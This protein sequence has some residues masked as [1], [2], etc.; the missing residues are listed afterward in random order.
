MQ[1]AF[2]RTAIPVGRAQFRKRGS[3]RSRRPSPSRLKERTVTEIAADGQTSGKTLSCMNRPDCSTMRPQDGADQ[4]HARDDRVEACAY[5]R[6]PGQAPAARS[7]RRRKCP[8]SRD[9]SSGMHTSCGLSGNV[10]RNL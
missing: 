7:G 9:V 1:M 8:V 3:R 4:V 10:A 6:A 5:R 2:K